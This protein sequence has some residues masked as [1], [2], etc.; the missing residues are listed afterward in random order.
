MI[1]IAIP[2]LVAVF[3]LLV[4]ALSVHKSVGLVVMGCGLLVAVYMVA[5]HVAHWG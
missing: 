5:G 2:A 4:Y 3:G 1:T